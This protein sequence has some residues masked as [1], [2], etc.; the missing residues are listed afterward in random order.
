MATPKKFA[1]A[2]A[3]AQQILDAGDT[4]VAQIQGRAVVLLATTG[5]R[6]GQ[7]RHVPLMRV[8]HDGSYA[9]VAS[10]GG[11]ERDPQWAHNLRAHPDV[12]VL[13]G[14]QHHATRVRELPV[15]DERDGWWQRCV[16]AF[17]PYAE[18]QDTAERLIPVFLLEPAG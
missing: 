15:G 16:A 3:Q 17:P 7:T 9:A 14:T 18:Y 1:W 4:A 11:Q 12:D 5:A 8:E 13:D 2:A 10:A 6:S